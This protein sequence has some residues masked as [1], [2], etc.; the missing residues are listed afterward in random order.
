MRRREF[1]LGLGSAATWPLAARAQQPAMPVVGYL[2]SRSAES[3]APFLGAFRQGLGEVG[4][5]EGRNVRIEYRWAEAQL[6]RLPAL[7]ADLVQLRPAVIV[8]AGGPAAPA[9]K[10]ATSSIPIV[11]STGSDP[12]GV[13]LV[14]SMNR[15]GGNL[16]GVTNFSRALGSKR[17]ELMRQLLPKASALAV[18]ANPDS[19]DAAYQTMDVQAAARAV[20]WEVL[21][22]NAHTDR[23]IDSAFASMVEH[24]VGGLMVNVD[25]FFFT[26]R[27]YIIARAA[28]HSIPTFYGLGEF[29]PAG[30]LI[31][32]S[33][34]FTQ[35]YQQV[36]VYAARILNGEKPADLPVLQPTR[37]E[38]VINMRTAKALGLDVPPAL[39][40]IADEVIE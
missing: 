33:T 1:I 29:P 24:R 9:A 26:R 20:G 13:G 21:V 12:V 39:L 15:P 37:F 6:R 30:G 14:A 27:D 23:E 36:G 18:L 40:A 38:L 11:F 7:A 3:D 34:S 22:L 31:S 17:V 25:G 19:P 2:G 10:A 32:Y 4:Y 5:V 8:T 35:I 16:T 28:R